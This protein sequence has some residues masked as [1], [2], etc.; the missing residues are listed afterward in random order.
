MNKK[1]NKIF[2]GLLI[3]ALVF[4]FLPNEG[5]V[6][7]SDNEIY[8]YTPEELL[9]F[10]KDCSL[11][12]WSQGK[13]VEIGQDIDLTGFNFEGIPTFGG[14]FN[15]NGHTISGINMLQ[16]GSIQGFFRYIQETGTVVNCNVKG[17]VKTTGTK[18]ILGGIVGKNMGIVKNC[19]FIGN[20]EGD[21]SIGGIA[22]INEATGKIISCRSQGIIAGEHYIGGIVGQNLGVVLKST[23]VAKVNTAENDTTI[24][25]DDLEGL[26]VTHLN[27]TEN[28]KIKTDVGGIAGFSTGVLQECE[29]E[30]SVGYQ[31]VG[32]NVGGIVGRQSG[33]VYQCK[34]NGTVYGRKD[35]GGIA[36]QMEPYISLEYSQDKIGHLQEELDRLDDLM[37][38]TLDDAS[39]YSNSVTNQLDTTKGYVD[40][41]IDVTNSIADQTESLYNEGIDNINDLSSRVSTTL[42]QLEPILSEA[43]TLGDQISEAIDAFEKVAD[44]LEETSDVG[45]DALAK[46]DDALSSLR[47]NVGDYT[48]AMDTISQ[49][50]SDLKESV[51]DSAAMKQAINE[52][53]SGLGDLASSLKKIGEG[54]NDLSSAMQAL[55]KWADQ[56]EDW[57]NLTKGLQ[58]AA[59]ALKDMSIAASDAMEALNKV[60]KAVNTDDIKEGLEQLEKASQDFSEAATH[61][62]EALDAATDGLGD[63]DAA[64][65]YL[66]EAIADVQSGINAVQEGIK[67][68]ERAVTNEEIEKAMEELEDALTRLSK[69][70]DEAAK[71]SEKLSSGLDGIHNSIQN[72]E[73]KE[74]EEQIR[75]GMDEI[76]NGMSALSDSTK[77]IQS[78]IS[79]INDQVRLTY[80]EDAADDLQTALKQLTN[81]GDETKD[82]ISEVKKVVTATKE[83]V[84]VG[85]EAL[86]NFEEAVTALSEIGETASSIVNKTHHIISDLAQR[87]ELVFPNLNSDYIANVND[88]SS[89]LGNISTVLGGLNELVGENNDRLIEDVRRVNKQF[90][91]VIDT[92]VDMTLDKQ[93]EDEEGLLAVKDEISEDISD[94]DTEANTQGKVAQ[95]SNMG[96]VEGDV[97]VGGIAGSMAIEYDFDPEDDVTK[98]GQS[99]L[100]FQYLA[101]TVIRGCMN[102]G[103]VTSKKDDV[104]GIVGRMDLG[105]VIDSVAYGVIKSGDGNFVGGIA[106]SAYSHI[107]EC[108]AMCVL[109]GVNNV[110]GIAGYAERLTD[111]HALVDIEAAKESKGAIAGSVN[112][113]K[114]IT[115]NDFVDRGVAAIDSISYSGKAAPIAYEAFC[116]MPR[117]PE[118]FKTLH[119]TF[120]ADGR[121]IGSVPFAF[122]GSI[123]QSDIPEMPKKEGYYG[124]WPE[125]DFKHLTFTTT[126]EAIYVPYTQI[127]ASEEKEGGKSLALIEGTFGEET[128]LS[129]TEA[130]VVAPKEAKGQTTLWRVIVS[131]PAYDTK[132]DYELRLLA[133]EDKKVKVYALNANG[134]WDKVNA[135]RNGSY[136]IV[137][138][139]GDIETF[140][141]AEGG[142]PVAL[143]IGIMAAAILLIGILICMRKKKHSRQIEK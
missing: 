68:L 142:S 111:N 25:L 72:G 34:N 46:L 47:D 56:S 55:K 28:M 127:V 49:A 132:K 73:L 24:T 48:K 8:I 91:V 15:G 89:T 63:L 98:V 112:S 118:E 100:K 94:E 88:L 128:V 74:V 65:A 35:V 22:G 12:T 53:V 14:Y 38:K 66:N 3:L 97:N 75:K 20:V 136:M 40:K 133:P 27:D 41:A 77:K 52:L 104:G 17:T 13:H 90:N 51:G 139:R 126:L 81:A 135:T 21:S 119:I 76:A 4:S 70:M 105:T 60:L 131:G 87:P 62:Q 83:T 143:Y 84:E 106:G 123:A 59:T 110:G 121:E 129:V 108:F 130:D 92:L 42:D 86:K 95:S 140:C 137:K 78:A 33:Y 71:A 114:A 23:N 101:R 1:Q 58:E 2:I 99:S 116:K 93:E 120:V 96:V 107:K 43:K 11:D 61:L 18:K 67:A 45:K 16:S 117:V 102:K 79:K 134:I 85:D 19:R 141:L 39:G 29:N 31:H 37:N 32:Y 115:N 7:A 54:V 30:G 26:D 138:M 69:A 103:E 125:F 36:G 113:L 10:A 122:G 124:K 57:K 64:K 5:C 109:S 50:M 9:D 82:V 44:Q 80:L 6:L